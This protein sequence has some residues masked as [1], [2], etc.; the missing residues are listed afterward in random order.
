MKTAPPENIYQVGTLVYTRAG[1][2]LV[3]GYLLWGDF[4]FTLMEQVVPSLLPLLLKTHGAS[5]QAIAILVGTVAA[6]FNAIITPTFSYLSDRHRGPLGRRIP[7]LIWPTPLIVITLALMPFSPEIAGYLQQFEPVRNFFANSPINLVVLTIGVLTI[8]YQMVNMVVASIYYY[9]FND[10]VPEHL[11]GRFFALFRV[12]GTLGGFFFNYFIFGLAG[13]HMREIFVGLALLYGLAFALM[14]WKVKEGNYPPVKNEAKGS[15]TAGFRNYFSQCFCH[16]IYRWFYLSYACFY[17]STASIIFW[18]FFLR[19]EIGLTLDVIGKFRSWASLFVVLL[20]YPFGMLVDRWKSQRVILLGTTLL[21]ASN[22]ACYF[23]ISD[24]WTY[25]ICVSIW[26][27]ASF[28]VAIANAVWFPDLLPKS[29]YGQFASAASLVTSLFM[30]ILNPL[31]GWLLDFTLD[32]RFA[33]LWSALF[34]IASCLCLI[35]VHQYWIRFG[36][37]HNYVAPEPGDEAASR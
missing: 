13:T 26:T 8:M 10:V 27:V 23:F 25:L 5:N 28:L 22:L 11:L 14:C 12:V 24:K 36:G 37:P 32:Y 16:P 6:V 19:D 18:V 29:R 3:F 31:C 9:L 1:L 7:F 2:V 20:A 21:A 17:W 33:F 35:K 30:I 15:L 34:L 4:C